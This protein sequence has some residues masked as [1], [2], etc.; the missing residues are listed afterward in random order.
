M[1]KISVIIPYKQRLRN[2]RL[3][4][5]CLA[6]QTVGADTFEVVVGVMEYDPGYT[7]MCAE[8]TSRVDIVSVLTA[9]S[10]QTSYARNI[11]LRQARGEVVLFLDA[12]MAVP[13][14]FLENL[15]ERH[16]ASGQDV[17]IAGQ[18]IDYDN[19]ATEVVHVAAR[20]YAYYADL[21]DRLEQHG[22]IQE[23]PR[24]AV[25]HVIPWAFAWTALI[26][27]PRTTIEQHRLFFDLG[28]HGYG[29]E[30]LEWAYRVSAAGVP[31]RMAADVYGIHLPHVRSL[32]ANQHSEEL[33]YRYFLGTWPGPEVELACAFGDFE[34][35]A[36]YREFHDEIGRAFGGLGAQARPAVLRGIVDGTDTM[37]VGAAIS[38]DGPLLTPSLA[39]SF[40]GE[41]QVLPLV[42]LALPLA[43]AEIE[44]CVIMPSVDCLAEVYR[45]R[46]LAEAHRVARCTEQVTHHDRPQSLTETTAPVIRGTRR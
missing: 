2:L 5:E 27:L 4:L 34:A 22:E 43:D 19:N 29:V 7:E 28:F 30:D 36:R 14:H 18:M 42:G 6:R 39:V 38:P 16:F 37:I 23:D 8:F 24:L 1:K 31:I 11:A 41:P 17:C 3:A 40:T 46:V 21:L 44:R 9:R 10:W 35:N 26:A 45:D 13:P 12:D 32:R 15:Y 20:P 25:E 33:N